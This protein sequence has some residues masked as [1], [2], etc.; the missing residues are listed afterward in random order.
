MGK[1]LDMADKRT[2]ADRKSQDKK[3]QMIS[4]QLFEYLRERERDF[5]IFTCYCIYSFYS[6]GN[7]S[8]N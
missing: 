7:S 1:K 2:L 6:L 3:T 5:E 8:L 4:I